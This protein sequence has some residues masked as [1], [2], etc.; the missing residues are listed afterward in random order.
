MVTIITNIN[1]RDE[2][3]SMMERGLSQAKSG[4]SIPYEEAFESL[5]KGLQHSKRNQL[6]QLAAMK[7]E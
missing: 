4:D 5:M 7:K 6:D 2:F 1:D 3:D